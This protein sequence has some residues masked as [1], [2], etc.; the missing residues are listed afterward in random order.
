MPKWEKAMAPHSSILAW[1]IPWTEEP[2][3]LQSMGS[4]RVRH[5]W[6]T[7]LSLPLKLSRCFLVEWAGEGEGVEISLVFFPPN[8]SAIKFHKSYL[9][10]FNLSF[11]LRSVGSFWSLTLATSF[12]SDTSIHTWTKTTGFRTTALGKSTWRKEH[13]RK[14]DRE[15][16]ARRGTQ[17]CVHAA[18]AWTREPSVFRQNTEDTEKNASNTKRR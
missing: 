15:V 11:H 10:F 3:R 2:G 8:N 1:N 17:R 12:R 9:C 18:E 5:D 7:S 14:T 13:D 4:L 6:A 16:S